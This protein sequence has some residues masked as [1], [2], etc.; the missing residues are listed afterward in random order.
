MLHFGMRTTFSNAD[1]SYKLLDA[2]WVG[3]SQ[4]NIIVLDKYLAMNGNE[5]CKIPGGLLLSI[6]PL[7]YF[8]EEFYMYFVLPSSSHEQTSFPPVEKIGFS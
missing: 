2:C 6:S 7:I 4:G 5:T 8:W 3:S 1:E